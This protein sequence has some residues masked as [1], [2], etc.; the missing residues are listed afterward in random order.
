MYIYWVLMGVVVLGVVMVICGVVWLRKVD[1]H[2]YCGEC[3][4]NLSGVVIDLRKKENR[5]GG[6]CAECGGKLDVFGGVRVGREV[7]RKD[8]IVMGVTVVIGGVF[9]IGGVKL[10]G[11]YCY[12]KP[13]WMLVWELEHPGWS[14]NVEQAKNEFALI[15]VHGRGVSDD[16]AKDWGMRMLVGLTNARGKRERELYAAVLKNLNKAGRLD[17]ERVKGWLNESLGG[18][19]IEG[20]SGISVESW[21]DCGVFLLDLESEG[22][23]WPG[24]VRRCRMKI[25]GVLVGEEEDPFVQQWVRSLGNKKGEFVREKDFKMV[26]AREGVLRELIKEGENRLEVGLGIEQIDGETGEKYWA[27]VWVQPMFFEG[28][29]GERRKAKVVVDEK[30]VKK[31]MEIYQEDGVLEE[32][33]VSEEAEGKDF[34]IGG[35]AAYEMWGKK[36]FYAFE[37][38]LCVDGVEY[39]QGY[40]SQSERFS[41]RKILGRRVMRLPG[42]VEGDWGELKLRV[43]R[44]YA[45]DV[46]HVDEVVD[47]EINLGRVKILRVSEEEMKKAGGD[48]RLMRE[49]VLV[50]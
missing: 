42:N 24:E 6:K 35:R 22:V 18:L 48:V 44:E 29:M 25:N 27:Y 50:K 13:N 16:K 23:S 10:S 34:P 11:G 4:Y 32:V 43:S 38:L 46:L 30:G 41:L 45:Y 20:P 28:V 17:R 8:L 3:G 2:P 36:K 49:K 26:D 1:E 21:N 5:K 31:M 14:A 33:V 47:G 15:R 37:V 19:E 7:V 12:L 39:G 40:V 9:L